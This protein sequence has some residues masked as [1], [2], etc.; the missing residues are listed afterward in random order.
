MQIKLDFPDFVP[1]WVRLAVGFVVLGVFLSVYIGSCIW[2][3]RD[4][5]QRGK[6]GCLVGLLVFV[7]WPIGLLLWIAARPDALKI[8]PPRSQEK[9]CSHPGCGAEVRR[10][11]TILGRA[12]YTCSDGHEFTDPEA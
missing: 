11:G 12:A 7:S 3:A 5:G 2:A 6:S 4:A 10:T 8:Q 9:R 1:V